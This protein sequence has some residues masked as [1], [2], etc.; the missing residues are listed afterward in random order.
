MTD[1]ITLLT[2]PSTSNGFTALHP[3]VHENHITLPS[4]PLS[5][6]ARL[7]AD[8]DPGSAS[9][10]RAGAPSTSR[11]VV[12]GGPVRVSISGHFREWL[13]TILNGQL[14]LSH[15]IPEQLRTQHQIDGPLSLLRRCMRI[16]LTRDTTDALPLT[17]ERIYAL[18]R[19]AVV[20]HNKGEVLADM[21]KIELDQSVACLE[22][23]L[24][25]DVSEGIGFALPFAQALRWFERQVGLLADV[26]TYLDRG[27][28][29]QTKEGKGLQFVP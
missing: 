27:Y 6:V 7:D 25:D 22:R 11:P 3:S 18:C 15:P 12:A 29:P 19:D 20:I 14:Q 28:L 1:L 10:S 16:I 23:G 26:M 13:W 2:F 5:K 8:S 4:L 21:L 17:Y 9:R 24:T